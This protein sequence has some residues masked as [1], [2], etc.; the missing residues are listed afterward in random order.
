MRTLLTRTGAAGSSGRRALTDLLLTVSGASRDVLRDAPKERTKQ[1]AMGAVLC[2]TAA[3]AA[4]S[5]AYALHI[6]LHLPVVLAVL[7][8]LAWGLVI[9][10]LDR[11]LVVST[12]R[13]RTKFGT[14][15]MALPRVLLAVLIGAGI[16]TPLTLAVFSAEIDVKV[17][18]MAA[19]KD[20]E[21][22]K[23]LDED[24]R[25]TP[26][27]DWQQKIA[28]LQAEIADGATDADVNADPAVV[29]L[30]T[31]LTSTTEAYNKAAQDVVDEV[32][33]DSPTGVPGRGDAYWDKVAERDRLKTEV[34]NLQ[35]QLDEL[36]PQVK[37]QLEEL[38]KKQSEDQ[39]AEVA[40]LQGKVAAA[41]A[42]RASEIA[43][44]KAEVDN[45]DGILAR[46]SA[47]GRIQDDNPLLGTA[48][49][50]L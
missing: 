50:L 13:L 35:R 45:S 15:L 10:N 49:L 30:Q 37:G 24:S 20:D 23:Q 44:H 19:E 36:K 8:G 34:D 29:A 2:S 25:F 22:N 46:L 16:S 1:V 47:L 26:I 32:V 17:Q 18:E 28:D 6:A 5:A 39:R 21:F 38:D 4:V 31:Q 11:W 48:H 14:L 3:I 27:P 7:G 43:A 12:P 41:E 40:D 33:G 9:L 42:T